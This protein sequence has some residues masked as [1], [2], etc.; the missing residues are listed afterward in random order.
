MNHEAIVPTS[1]KNTL[2]QSRIRRSVTAPGSKR[3]PAANS[4]RLAPDLFAP[5][6]YCTRA[7]KCVEGSNH[8]FIPAEAHKPLLS[9]IQ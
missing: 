4:S 9:R 1:T 3:V 8:P 2:A 6:L 5:T 7:G